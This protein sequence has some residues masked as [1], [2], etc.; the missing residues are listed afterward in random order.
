MLKGVILKVL[1]RKKALL[2]VVAIAILAT[3]L[4]VVAV[5]K[6]NPNIEKK[7]TGSVSS[8]KGSS[9]TIT[10]ETIPPSDTTPPI[11]TGVENGK[12]Y[13][14][15]V[16]A[17][18]TG[19]TALLDG[20]TYLSGTEINTLGNHTLVVTDNSKNVTT[21]TFATIS[22]I[23]T[24]TKSPNSSANAGTNTNSKANPSVVSSGGQLQQSA[25]ITTLYGNHKY[26][27]ANQEQYNK[28][29]SIVKP[30]VDSWTSVSLNKGNIAEF[31]D[32]I[33]GKITKSGAQNID[34]YDL[35]E[36]EYYKSVSLDK[37]E[38]LKIMKLSGVAASLFMK[39]SNEFL[40]TDLT[41][42]LKSMNDSPDGISGLILQVLAYTSVFD[43]A[44]Y[45]TIILG[46]DVSTSTVAVK[47]GDRWVAVFC[48]NPNS[49]HDKI[50]ETPTYGSENL[51]T[52]KIKYRW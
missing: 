1:A 7:K 39:N 21:I 8:S 46:G 2:I 13:E 49:N 3:T 16:T 42:E 11:I 10:N 5:N 15:K 44:G 29:M 35:K 24:D 51:S 14:E 23:S 45:N 37:G 12:Q 52:I 32:Y 26:G 43:C 34:F 38:I 17:I 18:F 20:A 41:T 4:V 6:N 9:K 25:Q 33:D 48:S 22:K 30:A 31:E 50:I 28:L 40:P 36:L 19:G 47:I 27:K